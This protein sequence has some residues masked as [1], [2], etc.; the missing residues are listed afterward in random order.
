[1]SAHSLAVAACAVGA[2]LVAI[3]HWIAVARRHRTWAFAT[4]PAVLVLL[5]ALALV[6]G[7]W[8][9]PGGRWLLA[10]LAMGLVGD[11]LLLGEGEGAFLG[12]LAAFLLGHLAYVACFLTVDGEPAGRWWL[13]VPALLA[14]LVAIRRVWAAAVRAGGP[15]LV[16]AVGLYV[17]VS[18]ALLVVAFRSGHWLVAG[19]AT[20]FVA[21]DTLLARDRFVG[22]R[23]WNDL[24]V[25][26]TYH[27]AQM[28]LV[29]GWY[30]A[31]ASRLAPA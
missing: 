25:M 9:E 8:E 13:A 28:A 2:L 4:K 27:L 11:V 6:L 20:V 18:A 3:V 10:A 12:G 17:L 26:V 15:V 24:A 5:L 7:A 29:W 1:M 30:Y 23:A 22:A 31:V 14:C 19:G 16:V 21:S